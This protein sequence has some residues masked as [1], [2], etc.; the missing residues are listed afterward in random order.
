MA[1]L[2]PII[3][4]LFKESGQE[5]LI[6]TGGGVN[7]RTPAGLLP[8]LKQNLTTQQILGAI[9]ELVPAEQRASFPPEGTTVFPYAAPA[10]QVQVTLENAQGRVKVSII[11]PPAPAVEEKLE[12][13]SPY[14]MLEMAAQA[15]EPAPV[16][17]DTAEPGLE[18]V[19]DTHWLE[20]S[21]APVLSTPPAP[22]A[23]AAPVIVPPA[24]A[25]PV[26]A[27][28]RPVAVTP[29]P[30]PA[31][32][33]AEAA[34]VGAP[35]APVSPAAAAS[36][37]RTAPA[38]PA[39][40]PPMPG[41]PAPAAVPASARPMA[42]VAGPATH[43]PLP[44]APVPAAAVAPAA[45]VGPA[46]HPPLPGTAAT[47]A[48]SS[49]SSAAASPVAAM[50]IASPAP[51][52]PA[53]P[54]TMP[55]VPAASPV[56]AVPAGPATMPP[57]PAA[58][59]VHAVPAGPATMPPVPAAS[60]VHAAPAAV[61]PAP[62]AASPAVAAA[63]MPV[64]AAGPATLPPVPVSAPAPVAAAPVAAAVP[65]T[66]PP[67]PVSVA[68][69]VAAAPVTQPPVPVASVPV[70]TVAP[71]AASVPATQPPLSIAAAAAAP[72]RALTPAPMPAIALAPASA[73]DAPSPAAAPLTAEEVE[74]HRKDAEAQMLALMEAML[75]RG[76]SDLH[77]SS[78]TLPHMRIDGDMVPIEE[79]GLITPGRLKAMIFSIAPEKNRKQW[80]DLH[81]TDFAYE[82]TA[83]RFR[84]N[85]FED[86]KGIGAVLRQIPNKIRTAEEIGLSRHVL[87][88]CFLTKGLVLVT[89]PTGSGKST[90]LAALID[91]VNRHREDHI[92]TVEDPIEFVHKNKS[93]LVNQREV[94]VHTQSFKNAL[95][96]ALREDPDVVLVGEMR[97]LETIATAIET[98]ETGHLVFGTLH[99]NTAAST[100]DRIID[101]FPADRQ[102][103][104][105]MM[106]SES[107]KG[108]IAQTLCK[109]I[110][111]GRVA[112]QEVL[113]CTG[114]VSNLIREG[115]T[116]QIPSV[117]QT[118]RGQGMVT[119]NDSLLDLVKKKVVEPNEALS[120][121][122]ARAELRAMLERAGFKADPPVTGAGT[123]AGSTETPAPTK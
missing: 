85:V 78:E 96:A 72:A 99:T 30:V 25:A 50:P 109:R 8:V 76:A 19:S 86:R 28:A 55:P 67:V 120:K 37:V 42:Q 100:V 51:V 20:M 82:T 36:A 59:P 57:V 18:L 48:G 13:A 14:E 27:V 31:G 88:M 106:L 91:Y 108:V 21:S 112:A 79:Y 35:Q 24:P 54:A 69:A 32:A 10:G 75:A 81:D 11:Q 61:A 22:V 56:H 7:M 104:I 118:S 114:S 74:D 80:E 110:G 103:Q 70:A 12:L 84:V 17:P 65:A 9:S 44:G 73:P 39:T 46:T 119:L 5:L 101:Q 123:A 111:G 33:L 45:S 2:D 63:A 26:A 115:K 6:E 15:S 121:S 105:R 34:G 3:E 77:L 40:I 83:A 62:V 113:L 58:S 60:P 47:A 98:A 116:F 23:P 38:R 122:V 66:Q 93:C 64:A 71:A 90:T 4:K 92:I 89:G 95:R 16:L 87:D 117:M 94:G 52:A 97:D 107:L 43:P 53:G 49:A 41:V 68:P 102:P 1:R 29:A